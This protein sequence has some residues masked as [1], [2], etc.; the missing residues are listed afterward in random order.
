MYSRLVLALL[1]ALAPLLPLFAQF[2]GRQITGYVRAEGST[3]APPATTVSL[4][5]SGGG[6]LEETTASG[7][8]YFKFESLHKGVYYVVARAPGYRE[9]SQRVEVLLI[10]LVSIRVTLIPDRREPKP[11]PEP[12]PEAALVDQRQLRIPDTA[13]K[14]FDAAVHELFEKKDPQAAVPHLQKAV[15]LYPEYYE[16]YHLLGTTYMDLQK[17]DEAEAA[18]KHALEITDE[19]AP[20]YTT[21]GALYNRQQKFDQALPLLERALELNGDSWQCRFELARTLL[22]QGKARQALPHA[23][24]AHEQ[25]PQFPLVHL[26]LGNVHL[27]LRN[28]QKGQEEYRHFLALVPQG[29]LANQVRARLQKVDELLGRAQPQDH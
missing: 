15:D 22:A 25:A 23:R 19:Y 18:L 26:V 5:L 27:R 24:Q 16:S 17:W 20:A 2:T 11:A 29:P 10:P 28:L 6:V 3:E 1:C 13:H 4:Q 12:P 7:D 14:E 21:L 8:G 9:V